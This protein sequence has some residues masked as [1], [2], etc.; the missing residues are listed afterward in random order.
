VPRRLQPIL[1]AVLLALP[2]I[3]SACAR[4]LI[5]T[6]DDLTITTQVKTALLNDPD[7]GGMRIDVE[8]V[9][10]V[11]TLSGGVKTAAERDKAVAITR[12]VGGVRD[13]KSVLEIR[14]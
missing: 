12:K 7:V 14:P 11:V 1:L 8:T 6:S 9:K 3:A 4:T 13:V 10:G 2:L 5:D